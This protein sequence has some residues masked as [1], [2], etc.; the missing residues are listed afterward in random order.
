[1]VLAILEEL[2]KVFHH[3]KSNLKIV[4]TDILMHYNVE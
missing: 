4:R 2:F 3:D 1:M